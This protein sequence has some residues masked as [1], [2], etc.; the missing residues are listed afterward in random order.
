M[1]RNQNSRQ[2]MCSSQNHPHSPFRAS[3]L[4]AVLFS[5]AATSAQAADLGNGFE[6]TGYL[7]GGVFSSAAGM[8][9]GGYTLGGDFQKYRLGNEGDNGIEV[10][11][12]KTFDAGN[13][14]KWSVDYMPTVWN[15]T[16]YTQQ[17]Y[18]EMTGLDFAPAAKFWAGQRRLRIQDVHIN[19]HF[20]MDYGINFGAGMTDYS[21]GFAKLGLGVFNGGSEDNHNSTANNA[22]RINVDLSDIK[23]N[24][25]GVLRVLGTV[26]SGNFQYATPGS[27]LSVSHNQSDFIIKGLT[28]TLFL[29]GS[30][31]HAGIDGRFQGLGDG[32]AATIADVAA[33]QQ[34]GLQSS[35]IGE[36]INWQSGDFG[37]QAVVV[38]QN[39]KQQGGLTG[40]GI[41]TKDFSIGGRI[42]YALTNNFKLLAEAGNTSRQIDGQ[43][44]QTLNKITFA[45][46]L[47]LAR[48]F[49]SRPELRFY[50]T[51]ASWN[52]AAAT[53]N[54]GSFGAGGKTSATTAGVQIETWW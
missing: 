10:E 12:R 23:I 6:T 38:L 7:R 28:N 11:V 22:R 33:T 32:I 49:W 30:T 18:A 16:N 27:A 45:P 48:D 17:A 5:V 53:A 29:Q 15:G 14:M 34:P 47:A 42:S 50:V 3:R 37:G 39:G 51:R 40:D 25:G 1:T 21:L 19:D 35:R 41:N 13:G 46:T 54:A 8:P 43:T 24:E 2:A 36:S 52:D 9:R 31:G 4:A 26:V 20:F 44:R